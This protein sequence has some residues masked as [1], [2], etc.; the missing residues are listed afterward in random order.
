MDGDHFW[1]LS[2]EIIQFIV[3]YSFL[4][5]GLFGIFFLSFSSNGDRYLHAAFIVEDHIYKKKNE[6]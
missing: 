2:Q 4:I 3:E 5:F 6:Y 1:R